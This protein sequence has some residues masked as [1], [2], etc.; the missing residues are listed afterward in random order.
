[1]NK[2]FL[3]YENRPI[4]AVIF[5][6]DGTIVPNRDYHLAAWRRLCF[7]EQFDVS[8]QELLATFGCTNSEI[9]SQLG[10]GTLSEQQKLR[11]A[12]RKESLYREYYSGK[13]LP[14]K[15]LTT[16]LSV[17]NRMN[18]PLALAT[19]APA[20]NVDFTLL[21]SG[22][23]EW[24]GVITDSTGIVHGKPH[25][26]IFLKTARS[27]GVNPDECLV[28][29]DAPHGLAAARAAGMAMIAL[30]TTFSPQQLPSDVCHIPDYTRLKVWQNILSIVEL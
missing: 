11:L 29:E 12:D 9:F 5:D 7:E 3:L 6:M 16:L 30:T 23:G 10:K 25:P 18:I 14:V 20:A 24:F 2:P 8:D 27:L 22:L 1:M 17:L 13:V 21:Q 19:S 28:F 15:G 4:K 26:E